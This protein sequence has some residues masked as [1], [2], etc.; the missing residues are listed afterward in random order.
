MEK[1]SKAVIEKVNLEAKGIIDKAEEKAKEKIAKSKLEFNAKLEKEKQKKI[2][3]AEEESARISS[4][5]LIKIRQDIVVAKSE[6][7]DEVMEKVKH[8]LAETSMDRKAFLNLAKEA[9]KALNLKDIIIYVP[10]NEAERIKEFL[11]DEKELHGK[12]KE[13]KEGDFIGGFIMES[14]DGKLRIDDTFATRLEMLLPR[15]KPEITRELF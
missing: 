12:V 2:Q 11:K 9:L 14:A 10:R 6:V 3:D 13:I 5:V 1:I 7:I 15:I 4:R 8:R